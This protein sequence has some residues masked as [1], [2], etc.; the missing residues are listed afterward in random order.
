MDKPKQKN[1]RPRFP[2]IASPRSGKPSRH[3][4]EGDDPF[5][6]KFEQFWKAGD[7]DSCVLMTTRL[8]TLT[9]E[10]ARVIVRTLGSGTL[11]PL[12]RL[13]TLD[14][15]AAEELSK[16]SAAVSLPSLTAL[17]RQVAGA[18]VGKSKNLKIYALDGLK[19]L[20]HDAAA[21]LARGC[22]LL[23]LNGLRSMS[24][25]TASALSRGAGQLFLDGPQKPT[26][27]CLEGLARGSKLCA[28]SASLISLGGITTRALSVKPLRRGR[29]SGFK[30]EVESKPARPTKKDNELLYGLTR[31]RRTLSLGG[32]RY[33][34]TETAEVLR[35]CR[36]GL[37]LPSVY[38]LESRALAALARLPGTLDL[39]GIRRLPVDGMAGV[40]ALVSRKGPCD[41]GRWCIMGRRARMLLRAVGQLRLADRRPAELPP[42][43]A[44]ELHDPKLSWSR[45]DEVAKSICRDVFEAIA[46]TGP[47]AC[48]QPLSRWLTE[49][50]D[51]E[52][53]PLVVGRG[54]SGASCLE[55][56]YYLAGTVA[57]K[58]AQGDS[59]LQQACQDQAYLHCVKRSEEA[60]VTAI[61]GGG[62]LFKFLV[63]M[64]SNAARDGA[65]SYRRTRGESSSYDAQ[66]EVTG[67]AW[68]DKLAHKE[69]VAAVESMGIS[70][71]PADL[72]AEVLAQA[73]IDCAVAERELQALQSK[74]GG[75]R[76]RAKKIWLDA[77][78]WLEW[79]REKRRWSEKGER[80]LGQQK[81]IE[82]F[83]QR[84][85]GLPA[86]QT[87]LS[88][89][90]K[91]RRRIREQA[92]R[93]T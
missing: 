55:V 36:R 39:S 72:E 76:R 31:I 67:F 47:A 52:L 63:T 84:H 35:R 6:R 93:V 33:I 56:C 77:L 92:V 90:I 43:R 24:G 40:Y 29:R 45:R 44:H 60:E 81:F 79:T 11:I 88:R 8:E 48:E 87:R 86:D 82:I 23:R 7:R 54:P 83:R 70:T 51:V 4:S 37:F 28:D 89:V 19:S 17:D 10:R 73:E 66:D 2:P 53:G 34:S 25:K 71:T 78:L 38:F 80:K 20:D 62:H 74:G 27:E 58:M 26:Q 75:N 21:V 61:N 1:R 85:P 15:A 64:V 13:R 32:V 42:S 65:R 3:Y 12:F 5:I 68:A 41:L 18:L 46:S 30:V 69:P 57:A 49:R 14:V 91:Q 16:A 22:A 50:V 59:I 9:P